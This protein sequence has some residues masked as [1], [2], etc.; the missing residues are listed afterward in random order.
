MSNG[1]RLFEPGDRSP[2]THATLLVVEGRDAFGFFLALLKELGL[3][4]QIEVRNAGGITDWPN[5]LRVLPLISGF[6]AVTSLGL[7]RDSE[8]NPG[9]AFQEVCSALKGGGLSV[10]TAVLQPS[11]S[12]PAP[13]VTVMLL[14]DATTPGMLETLC[15]R[16][17]AGDLRVPCIHPFLACVEKAIGSPVKRPEKSRLYA[18]IA[19]RDEPWLLLGQAARAGYFPWTSPAFDEVKRFAQGLIAV[20]P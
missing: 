9:Q 1:A 16:A 11:V 2:I 19:V 13:R 10:P 7:A 5:Y 20:T 18:Y 3:K 8:A 12:P 17:M 6:D 14:P 15:W 4:D